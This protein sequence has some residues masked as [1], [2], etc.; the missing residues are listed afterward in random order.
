MKEIKK[1]VVGI[2]LLALIVFTVLFLANAYN[3][4]TIGHKAEKVADTFTEDIIGT[5]TGKYSVSKIRFEEGGNTSLTMLGV[6]LHG[7]YSDSYNLEKETHTLT[8]KYDTVLGVS[9]ERSYK[10]V[11]KEDSLTLTDTQLDSVVMNYSRVA[12]TA[13]A[14]D[15]GDVEESTPE[16][17]STVYNPGADVYNTALLGVWKGEKSGVSGYEFFDGGRVSVKVAGFSA[18]GT[19]TLT[20]ENSTGR[21]VLK[22][23]GPAVMGVNISNEYYVTIADDV[24]SLTQK[25]LESIVLT[26]I[27]QA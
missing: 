19:Y 7:T 16:E 13:A 25:G 1:A 5:W 17:D 26:Y 10:A 14:E 2:V 15:S 6:T 8:I 21:C 11:L 18:E 3:N 27:K 24:M 4:G 22:I 20:E 12:E 9:V 23:S